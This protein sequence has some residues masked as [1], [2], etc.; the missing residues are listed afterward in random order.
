MTLRGRAAAVAL[1]LALLCLVSSAPMNAALPSSSGQR[2]PRPPA[3]GRGAP[4]APSPGE[5]C[6]NK[7]Y[8]LNC[9]SFG[10]RYGKFCGV[11]HTG[12]PGAEPCDD[13]DECCKHHDEC[14]GAAGVAAAGCHTT[15]I[16][17]INKHLKEGNK[18]FS[19]RC[20]YDE[21]VPVMERGIQLTLALTGPSARGSPVGVAVPAG[22]A[23]V[24]GAM[25]RVQSSTPGGGVDW[26][27]RCC[28]GGCGRTY[29]RPAPL[30]THVNHGME[31]DDPEVAAMH[32]AYATTF[33]PSVYLRCVP[34]DGC[35]RSGHHVFHGAQAAA[36][37]A[38]CQFCSPPPP[39][40]PPPGVAL[41][42]SAAGVRALQR[43]HAPAPASAAHDAALAA[44]ARWCATSDVY[45][46]MPRTPLRG[47]AVGVCPA[48]RPVLFPLLDR[49]LAYADRFP[50]TD[51]RSYGAEGAVCVFAGLLLR[52]Y[53]SSSPAVVRK[54][55]ERRVRL[56]EAGDAVR[57]G[58]SVCGMQQLWRES[59]DGSELHNYQMEAGELPTTTSRSARRRKRRRSARARAAAAE[60]AEGGADAA[61]DGVPP[62]VVDAHRRAAKLTAVQELRRARQALD[63]ADLGMVSDAAAALPALDALHPPPAATS[64]EYSPP[65]EPPDLQRAPPSW[66]DN[67]D[68]VMRWGED[69]RRV[70]RRAPRLSA[71][72][73][74]WWRWE[75]IRD[76]DVPSWRLWVNRCLAGRC[77]SRTAAFLASGSVFALHKDDPAAREEREKRGEPLRVRPLGVGSVL[78]RLASA[79]ALG[80]VGADAREVMGPSFADDCG[81]ATAAAHVPR[82]FDEYCT[83]LSKVG[84]VVQDSKTRYV[85]H[86][87]DS[88]SE[89]RTVREK[90]A[91][92]GFRTPADDPVQDGAVYLGAPV[93]HYPEWMTGALGRRREAHATLLERIASFGTSGYGC[94]HGAMRLLVVCAVRQTGFLSRM[95]PPSELDPFL[96]AVD[97]ANISAAFSLLGLDACDQSTPRMEAA[98]VQMSM[99]ADFG[100]LNLALL[101]SEAPAAFYSAQSVVLPKLVREYGPALGPLYEA[102]RAEVSSVATSALPWAPNYKHRMHT[103]L[104]NLWASVAIDAGAVLD[105]DRSGAGDL[106]LETSGL[107]PADRSRP[108]DLTLAGWGG[109]ACDYMIDFA[110]VSSTTPTW[111]NDPRWCIPGI[112][113]TEAEHAKLAADRASSAPVQGVHRYYPFVV[114]DRGRL[115]KSALTVV[116]IFAVLLAVRNFPGGPSAP[117]SCFLRGQSVQALR[118]FV[119]GQPAEF[120]RHLSRTR[121]GLLQRVSAC[122]H[123]TLG[124]ILS[125]GV[126]MA[127]SDA[128]ARAHSA[129]SHVPASTPQSM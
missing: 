89:L 30:C 16:E 37:A 95:M 57:A 78:V 20:P 116:Y 55:A 8:E 92:G 12:C 117:T 47:T 103:A 52:P 72:H 127:K 69:Q 28:D 13:V 1:S 4:S 46:K 31:S 24:V 65:E 26:Q 119:A 68:E 91:P 88:E 9:D 62:A 129:S 33:D 35:P 123:G 126:Q 90:L 115:G 66:G 51:D 70:L 40:A 53:P 39:T 113:A 111:S 80:Q 6:S 109:A 48:A 22:A 34:R 105:W 94:H 76:L 15:F 93:S 97:A 120:R 42:A 74:D 18:G 29:R 71:G 101:Q 5:E 36:R 63:T 45:R 49:T 124:G 81:A 21:V 125:A 11:S 75:H 17:C 27:F 60:A 106:T 107:R 32:L 14:V 84:L 85:R 54:L 102:V 64:P 118:N 100:G 122:V 112:A 98:I 114:E 79:H 59:R 83:E 7:C 73:V 58:F 50:P 77:H 82:V 25:A 3:H 44:T 121:R 10:I 38:T 23:V 67:A 110:C 56:W 104:K 61:A 96:E 41:P 2:R 108:S 19:A 99:P 128:C 87:G 86:P 43:Q